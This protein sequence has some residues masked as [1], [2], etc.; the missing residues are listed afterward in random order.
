MFKTALYE[1]AAPAALK[2]TKSVMRILRS[3]QNAIRRALSMPHR[4]LA[5]LLLAPFFNLLLIAHGAVKREIF[6]L[7]QA[8]IALFALSVAVLS[9]VFLGHWLATWGATFA[10]WHK[11]GI[12]T[13]LV[14]VAGTNV[15]VMYAAIAKVGVFWVIRRRKA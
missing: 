8:L 7:A 1:I 6:A 13:A 5:R 2:G 12:V 14:H 15:S 3:E 4:V 9:I 11:F 10:L